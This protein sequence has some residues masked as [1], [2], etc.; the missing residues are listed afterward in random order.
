[1]STTTTDRELCRQTE[2]PA[3]TPLS[4]GCALRRR[5]S[6]PTSTATA[7]HQGDACRSSAL[8]CAA[9]LREPACA[10]RRRRRR[11]GRDAPPTWP[12]RS[13]AAPRTARRAGRP[14]R[15]VASKRQRSCASTC[16]Q[17][18]RRER[19]ARA[20]RRQRVA[21]VAPRSEVRHVRAAHLCGRSRTPASTVGFSPA[22]T[23]SP[24]APPSARS[25]SG[26][27]VA[28]AEPTPR[29]ARSGAS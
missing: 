14:G 19:E 4:N 28:P 11:R 1:M 12:T 2:T 20:A 26:P 25:A 18:R 5:D 23:Q 15:T 9:R 7:V 21:A 6:D 10:G 8:C 22:E 24:R 29:H 3:S 13:T 17:R 16:A 27:A